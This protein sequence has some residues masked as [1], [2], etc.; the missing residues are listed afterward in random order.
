MSNKKTVQLIIF[1]WDG[2]LMDSEQ[3]IV[4]AIQA[5]ISDL[6]LEPRNNN[7]CKDIIGLGLAEAIQALY[8]EFEASLLSEFIDRYRHH[9]FGNTIESI[10]FDGVIEMLDDLQSKGFKLAVA[11]GKGRAGLNKVLKETNTGRYFQATRCGEE[12][13]SKPHPQMLIELLAEFEMKPEQAMMVGD[14]VYD[15]EMAKAA[16]M[17]SSAVSYGVHEIERLQA[18]S[19]LSCHDNV[20]SLSSWLQSLT[21]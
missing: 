16:N 9:W 21:N 13:R 19:P 14:S 4:S 10:L 5:A 8:P 17:A 6:D 3:Q 2:T 18:F 7:Q 12:T 1:D 11:T 20:E 15:L